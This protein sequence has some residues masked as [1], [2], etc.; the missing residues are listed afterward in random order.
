MSTSP[1][2]LTRN[3][4]NSSS[5]PREYFLEER[6]E[7]SSSF[8]RRDVEPKLSN[9]HVFDKIRPLVCSIN[10]S[11]GES[12]GFFINHRGTLL[13][14][15]HN[16]PEENANERVQFTTDYVQIDY[17]IQG[18]PYFSQSSDGIVQGH[19]K[20]LDLYCLSSNVFS[21]IRMKWSSHNHLIMFNTLINSFKALAYVFGRMGFRPLG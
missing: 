8:Y 13:T 20:V 17:G 1:P 3:H 12:S 5:I 11:K 7:K 16:I 6:E 9:S 18:D 2:T 10:S 4:A 15:A 14:V 21:N 19:A